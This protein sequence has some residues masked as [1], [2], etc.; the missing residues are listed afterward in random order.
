MR[1]PLAV[2]K[3]QPSLFVVLPMLM[4]LDSPYIKRIARA[5]VLRYETVCHEEVSGMS[6]RR[7]QGLERSQRD[8]QEIGRKFADRRGVLNLPNQD[9]HHA[10]KAMVFG[11]Q[12]SNCMKHVHCQLIELSPIE[13]FG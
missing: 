6:F 3:S 7:P 13:S 12:L 9:R 4:F 8:Q 5:T 10:K 1:I 2:T 11:P